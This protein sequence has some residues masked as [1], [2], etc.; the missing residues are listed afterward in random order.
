MRLFINIVVDFIFVY[1]LE[2]SND[3][4]LRML[5]WWGLCPLTL[6]G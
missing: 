1:K 2:W 5:H 3:S 6:L 4:C